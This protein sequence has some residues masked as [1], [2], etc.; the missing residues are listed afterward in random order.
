MNPVWNNTFI[1][2]R[3]AGLVVM[4]AALSGTSNAVLNIPETP[5]IATQTTPPLTMLV[6]GKD[7]K[8]FYEAYNDASDI[9]GDGVLDVRFKPSITYYGLFDAN[10]CY[11]Y[12]SNLYSPSAAAT[13]GKC[14]GSTWSGNWLNYVTT[15]R[16]DALRKVFYGG[17]RE[18]DTTTQTILRRAY[19]PQDAHS[20]AKEY[21][22]ETV[23]GY[24]LKEYTPIDP[25][26]SNRRHFFGNVTMDGQSVPFLS[27]V[28]NSPN[29]VWVWASSER[30]VLNNDTHGGTRTNYRVR[31]EVCTATFHDGCK[32]Y[33]NG[34]YKPVGLLHDY[35]ENNKMLFGLLTG[36][37]NKNMSGGV[38]RKVVSSF[39]NEVDS[40][41]GIFTSNATI[42]GIFNA[43]R[44]R[45]YSGGAYRGGW[46]TTR[47]MDEGEFV[48]WGNPIGEML[49]ETLRYFAG[50]G[51]AT[52]A[53]ATSGSY[54]QEV[55]G[56]ASAA[57]WDNPYSSSSA[58]RAS[59]CAKPNI[60]TISDINPSFDSDQ[61][62]GAHFGSGFSGDMAGMNVTTLADTIT[63]NEP[64]VLGLHFIGQSGTVSDNAPTA[65]SVTSLGTIRGLAPEE[66]TK[67]GS[68]Y[69][70]SVAYYGRTKDLNSVQGT[71]ST[72]T[73]IV[74]LASPLPKIEIKSGS[75]TITLVPFAK[76]VGGSNI[77]STKGH[78]QPTDQIVDFYVDTIANT[79]TADRNTAINGG[80]YYAKFRINY[81]DVEQGADHDMDAISEY[82]ISLQAD[83]TVKVRVTPIYQAGGIQQNMGYI[84]SGT[85]QDG[86][87]L[88][89]QDENVE[90]P[91]YLN[92]PPGRNPGYCDV[93]TMPNDCKKLPYIG[94]SG[95]NAYSERTFTAGGSG[96]TLLK[97]PL[98]YAAKWGGFSDKNGNNIPDLAQE[99]DTDGDGVPDTYFLVQNPLKLKEALT[100]S[101]DTIVARSA[102]AGNI[103]SNGTQVTTNTMIFQSLFNSA[104]WS[105]ELNA[106][107]ITN[108]GVSSTPAWKASEQL[109]APASRNIFTRTTGSS[110][111]GVAFNWSSIASTQQTTLGSEQVL[112]YIRGDRSREI[113]NSGSLR[114]R[115]SALGDIVHSSPYYVKDTGTVYV[116]ANDGMLHAF[117][118]S[119]GVEQFAYIP[120][121]IFSKL[122]TLATA[123]YTHSFFVDGDVAVSTRTETP[124]KNILV[125]ATGRGAKGLF[126]LNVTNPASFSAS[127]VLWEYSG[128]DTDMGFVLGRPVIAK[129]NNGITAAIVG[130]G[131][132]STSGKAVLFVINL[133][134]GALITKL[135]TGVAGDNGLATP[136]VVDADANGTVDYVYAGDLKGNVWKFDLTAPSA[137]NW[138]SA[139]RSGVTPQPLFI[140]RNPSGGTQPI[141]AQITVAV[142]TVTGDPNIGKTFLLFGTGSYMTSSDTADA[143]LQTLYGLIDGS[144]QIASRSDLQERTLSSTTTVSGN[145]LRSVSAATA[146]DMA[147][148]RGWYI[149]LQ[150]PTARGERIVTSARLVY[151]LKPV[152]EVSSIIPDTDPCSPGGTGFLNFVS[153]FT[154][155]RLEFIFLDINADGKFDSLDTVNG[156][157]PSSIDPGVGMPGEPILVGE[158][159]VIGGSS[160]NIVTFKKN[161]GTTPKTGRLSWREIIRE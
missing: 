42:V 23:D 100:K 116:G 158:R 59:W 141:T 90:I 2:L 22:S 102:S 54:D 14:N 76:S 96:A 101:F 11:T 26:N 12:A 63:Q 86:V 112:N 20:W 117:N 107:S 51:S 99:W 130:N 57:S 122:P 37:Y 92:V 115:N 118:A 39:A 134:T 77:S 7:H 58:A 46:V 36:S 73:Y 44:I 138:R 111:S 71:Q 30:P 97:D 135:D 121:L 67:Q 93:A 126:G 41:N 127:N 133:E 72:D 70:A 74:A 16:I 35:G 113:Q 65:K 105:G 82:E 143:S 81:E 98:W 123:T 79:G 45:D 136:G 9:D 18:V 48:D 91:Y 148:K 84:V 28:T 34:Q 157:T 131:Y 154:G 25:P 29:R 144:T 33:P 87:Y 104:T 114:N 139:F 10:V 140:A 52:S 129:L 132:N 78:F 49:Y 110:P 83:G 94:G 38:L 27:V 142:D 66:P 153:P 55:F 156:T 109:P 146:N 4:L 137:G 60:V 147:G 15:S 50:K 159:N 161:F 6:S 108:S 56:N 24:R 89:V 124:N 61:L 43:M 103:T 64:G 119:T 95:A 31:V 150:D 32:L 53:F 151:A 3:S 5:L 145:V 8:L 47:S 1:G 152:L 62:P 106:F 68:Y 155:G 85:T 19:I 80:R 160:G 128:S 69:S 120:S 40:T 75:N 88:V 125:G 21:T 17:L 13:N 149:N